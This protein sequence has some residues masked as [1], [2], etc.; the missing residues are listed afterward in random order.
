MLKIDIF[1]A[2]EKLGKLVD[3]LEH[4]LWL[5]FG[6]EVAAYLVFVEFIILVEILKFIVV[7][8]CISVSDFFCHFLILFWKLEL[9]IFV[10]RYIK[11]SGVWIVLSNKLTNYIFRQL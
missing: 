2:L 4:R 3:A 8:V 10:V 11:K 9:A 7:E 5:A 1:V 6:D